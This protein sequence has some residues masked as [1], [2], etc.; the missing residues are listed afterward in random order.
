VFI[1]KFIKDI[2]IKG[3]KLKAIVYYRDRPGG[4]G[5]QFQQELAAEWCEQREIKIVGQV[6]ESEK[7]RKRSHRPELERALRLA[8]LAKAIIFI[9]S[10][11]QM[12]RNADVIGKMLNFNVQ[13]C[14]PDVASLSE[15]KGTREVLKVMASVAEFEVTETKARA[16]KA[17]D[18]IQKEIKTTGS[19]TT[20][21][22]KVITTLGN[23]KTT[24]LASAEAT[25]A[26][27]AQ[28]QDYVAEI[29]P[30]MQSLHDRGCR[31]SG[32]FAKSLTAKKI[33]SPRGRTKW[34]A[35]MA[36]NVMDNCGM[37]PAKSI[38]KTVVPFVAEKKDLVDTIDQSG[39][40]TAKD[41]VR[42]NPHM[43]ISMMLRRF[44]FSYGAI[45]KAKDE[46]AK[47]NN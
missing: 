17:Y 26:R 22:G 46:H 27:V 3:N 4:K 15:P 23:V 39:L 42:E 12:S 44:G 7:G 43:S 25:K 29:L 35:S 36:R 2:I 9:P 41:I 13:V 47:T 14:T 33:V 37:T 1:K 34:T 38:T 28:S 40:K 21:K 24:K 30:M 31:S 20:K 11:G 18:K 19:H 45:T 8:Q 16:Q 10:F 5:L 6:I 32:D